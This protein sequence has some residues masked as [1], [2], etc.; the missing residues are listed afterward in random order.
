[1]ELATCMVALGGDI[2]QTVEKYNVTPSEVA[3]LRVIH[4]N[5]AVFDIRPHSKSNRTSAFERARLISEYGRGMDGEIRCLA[6]ERLFPGVA[7]R[8][9]DSFSEIEQMDDEA[10]DIAHEVIEPLPEVVVPL[11][12]KP[13]AGGRRKKPQAPD[14]EGE[15]EHDEVLG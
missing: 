12:K 3:V 7:A 2:G 4:G 6:V 9:F 13:G 11:A 15:D 14:A 8:L 5:D 1:M 10:E